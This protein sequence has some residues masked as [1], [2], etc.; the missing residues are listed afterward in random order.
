MRYEI[1]DGV[2][3]RILNDSSDNPAEWE[4]E[5]Q[6]PHCKRWF[7][8]PFTT[9]CCGCGLPKPECICKKK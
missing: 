4:V 5:E 8:R 1:E 7:R 2:K 9:H 6:C 3:I